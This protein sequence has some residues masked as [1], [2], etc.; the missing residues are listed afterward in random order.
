M[1]RRYG[2]STE[3][4][5]HTLSNSSSAS[6]HS[7]ASTGTTGSHVSLRSEPHCASSAV[8]AAAVGSAYSSSQDADNGAFYGLPTLGNRPFITAVP[9]FRVIGAAAASSSTP[10][11][12]APPSSQS[13]QRQ[14]ASVV[15]SFVTPNHSAIQGDTN[16]QPQPAA[17][18]SWHLTQE[19]GYGVGATAQSQWAQPALQYSWQPQR[20]PHTVIG[21][22]S[23]SYME[24][25]S[26][27]ALQ[28]WQYSAWASIG[29]SDVAAPKRG[30]ELIDDPLAEARVGGGKKQRAGRSKTSQPMEGTT[31]S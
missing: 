13:S 24:P 2:S 11:M 19:S 16:R 27:V 21:S 29:V 28:P 9:T 23:P 18:V 8:T 6:F 4:A 7:T 10:C 22:P 20:E 3:S 31:L 1:L 14:P 25:P 17:G 26:V 15:L 5:A 30:G 12:A